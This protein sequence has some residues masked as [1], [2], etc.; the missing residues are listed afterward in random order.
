[1]RSSSAAGRAI[2]KGQVSSV[3][4]QLACEVPLL[5]EK[6]CGF[7][8]S[9]KTGGMCS[10]CYGK[11]HIQPLGNAVP[12]WVPPDGVLMAGVHSRPD[13]GVLATSENTS[14]TTDFPSRPRT[15][16][17]LRQKL[18][19]NYHVS[20]ISLSGKV[21]CL[22]CSCGFTCG[23]TAALE[24]HLSKFP[25][26][27]H[28]QPGV[29]E[30]EESRILGDIDPVLDAVVE[31]SCSEQASLDN[32]ACSTIMS[33]GSNCS[34]GI[35]TMPKPVPPPASEPLP[36]SVDAESCAICHSSVLELGLKELHCKAKVHVRCLKDFWL[37]K[38]LS[39]ERLTSVDCPVCCNILT[40]R[41]LNGVVDDDSIIRA[42]K[43]LQEIAERQQLVHVF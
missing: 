28:H 18:I 33:I 21:Q 1:M 22:G 37:R 38:V 8:G 20:D 39:S 10:R 27:L 17:S 32:R 41:D 11:C 16:P 13:I 5:C 15:A 4:S 35:V 26:D 19:D 25:G 23:T 12:P 30:D 9:P 43:Q 31:E 42:Y 34:T 36:W 6:G 24:K 2:G 3:R 7:Y 40:Q 29:H 14:T